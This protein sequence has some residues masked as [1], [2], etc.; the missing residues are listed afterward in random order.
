MTR[1]LMLRA[2]TSEA[3]KAIW[4]DFRRGYYYMAFEGAMSALEDFPDDVSLKHMSVLCLLRGGAFSAAEKLFF[5]LNLAEETH[6]DILAL[7]GRLAKG[8]IEDKTG[9]TRLDLYAKAA[10][11]YEKTYAQTQGSYSG[12]N[13]ATL[14]HLAGDKA[15]AQKIATAILKDGSGSNEAPENMSEQ[16]HYYFHATRAECLFILGQESQAAAAL[17]QALK[18]DPGNFGARAS[19]INQF[20]LLGQGRLPPCAVP[21][22]VPKT[23]HYTGHL[24]RVGAPGAERSLTEEETIKLSRDVTRLVTRN[25][26]SAAFG[27]LAAGVDIL[28]AEA[29]LEHGTDLH[30]VL[31]VPVEDFR[32]LSV[33]PMGEHWELRFDAA[34]AGAKSVRVILDDPGDFDELDLKMGSLIAMGLTRLTAEQLCTHPIQF[35]VMDE[36]IVS[37]VPT[38]TLQDTQLWRHVDGATENIAWPRPRQAKPKAGLPKSDGRIFRAMLFTDL[39]GYGKLPDRALPEIVSRIFAPMAAK[40]RNLD[41]APLQIKSWGDGLFLVFETPIAAAHAA[42]EIMSCFEDCVADAKSEYGGD[43]ALRI[44]VHFGPV[45]EREDP[46]TQTPNLYGRNVTTAA[47]LEALALPGSICVSE[48]FAAMLAMD[49]DSRANNFTCD[50]V[51]RTRSEKEDTVFSLYSLRKRGA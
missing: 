16:S 27:A 21:L 18:S 24:F 22:E 36:H 10:T 49:P 17:A 46:F 34:L 47:R 4:E 7:S 35:S 50:Y 43:L 6:E 23:A 38:G 11:L 37:A 32:R 41:I 51:G 40:C 26:I 39:K 20:K 48:N 31:P 9:Q 2:S 25:P 12:V 33:T 44:G 13:A 45:W 5:D 14:W 42:F 30:L 15:R 1:L 19:T 29:F 8:R 28:F 3:H